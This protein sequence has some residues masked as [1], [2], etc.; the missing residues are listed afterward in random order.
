MSAR[1][2]GIGAQK[3]DRVDVEREASFSSISMEA[4]YSSR[5]NMP[6]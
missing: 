4:A 3:L 5:S 2:Q 6:T 1:Y